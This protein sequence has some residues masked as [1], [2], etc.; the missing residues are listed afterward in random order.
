MSTPTMK[1]EIPNADFEKL[2]RE[3]IASKITEAMLGAPEITMK[4]VAAALSTK[5]DSSGAIGRYSTDNKT[6]YIE[7]L[8]R[9]LIRRSATVALQKHVAEMQ[10]AIEA[11]VAAQLAEQKDRIARLLARSIISGSVEARPRL[12][13]KVDIDE[14]S[15]ADDI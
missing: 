9:D 15:G 14:E 3:A 13:V 4:V 12:S 1:V 5:V 2:A 7:W 10:P 6:P 11:A 8:L